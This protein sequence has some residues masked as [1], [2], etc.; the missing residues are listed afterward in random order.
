[1]YSNYEEEKNLRQL[2]II[3]EKKEIFDKLEKENIIEKKKEKE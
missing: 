1:M 2:Q 3:L